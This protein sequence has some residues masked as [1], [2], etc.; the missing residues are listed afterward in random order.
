MDVEQFLIKQGWKKGQGLRPGSIKNAL[1]VKHRKD[2]KGLGFNPQ[3]SEGWWE[4]VFDGHLKSLDVTNGSKVQIEFDEEKRR[5]ETSPL[6]ASFNSGGLLKGTLEEKRRVEKA[7]SKSQTKHK[8]LSKRS[9]K[10]GKAK[11]K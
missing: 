1:L 7:K 11:R 4:R 10:E 2:N 5:R 3:E 9:K 8:N 6:Y